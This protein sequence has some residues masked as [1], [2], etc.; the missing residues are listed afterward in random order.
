MEKKFGRWYRE[1]LVE[2]L[3][4]KFDKS[5]YFFVA[6]L[7]RLKVS[8]LE[9]LRKNLKKRSA[10]FMVVKNSLA[11]L[12]FRKKQMDY[13]VELINGQTGV[14]LGG[15]DPIIISKVLVDYSKSFPEFKIKGGFIQDRVVSLGKIKEISQLPSRSVLMGKICGGFKGI[16]FRLANSLSLHVKLMFILKGLQEKKKEG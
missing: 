5:T 7:S 2:E 8:D 3:E 1:R 11:R 9:E 14:V 10:D 4:M 13:F 16:L 15:D 12:A 6:E